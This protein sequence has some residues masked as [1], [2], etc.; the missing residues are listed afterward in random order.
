MLNLLQNIVPADLIAF[1]RAV[2]VNQDYLLTREIVPN[3]TI[4][5]VKY[6]IKN[7]SRFGGVAKFRAYDAETPLG[8]REVSHSILEGFLPPV[9]QKLVVGELETILLALDRGQ[10]DQALVDALYDDV[11]NSVR[12]IRARMELAAG[13]LLVDGK[14]TLADE[15]GLTL[16][17]DFGV[18]SGFLPTASVLWSNPAALA[19]T[20]ERTWINYLVNNGTGAPADRMT[21]TRV[22]GFLATNQ[23]YKEAYYGRAQS[24]YPT[25]NPAQVNSVRDTYGLPPIKVYD[26][27]VRVDGVN[28][29]VTPDD[30]F[31]LLPGDKSQF[32][33]TQYG[34]TAEALA[35]SAGTGTSKLART[36]QPGIIVTTKE[37]DDPVRVWSKAGAVAMPLLYDNAAMICAKV[38]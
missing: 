35:L 22:L 12:A 1:A 37:E 7:V 28:Q 27:Q 21:S 23:E 11:D 15:N 4:Q 3:T 5:N 25:L 30:R 16:E 29:R 24:S 34:I 17:A 10:D 9:G 14:F 31:W 19:L 2:P 38:L 18:T 26:A 20:D 13:D 32:A 6:R 8:R 36:D 33:E